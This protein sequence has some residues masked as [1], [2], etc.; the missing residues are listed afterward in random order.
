[1]KN[2]LVAGGAGFIGSNLC[3]R[4]VHD[5]E[6]VICLDNFSSGRKTKLR[7]LL[8][9][10]NFEFIDHDI[11]NPY[12]CEDIEQI[13]NLACPASP[14]YYQEDPIQ[15]SKTSFFGAFHLLGLAKKINANDEND[16][17]FMNIGD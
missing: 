4:L 12:Y 11:C 17:R 9:E 7:S 2:I 13:Y 3:K 15:T 14:I 10:E 1:M 6:K 8:H 16:T 5:G